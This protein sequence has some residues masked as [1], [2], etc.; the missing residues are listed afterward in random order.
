MGSSRVFNAYSVWAVLAVPLVAAAVGSSVSCPDRCAC[1]AA[2]ATVVCSDWPLQRPLLLHAAPGTRLVLRNSSG[3]VP[4]DFFANVTG[5]Q[6]LELV[7]GA[8]LRLGAR[9]L[10][11]LHAVRR[12]AVVD[13][14]LAE[15]AP[16]VLALL[17]RLESLDLS[18]NRLS[19]LYHHQF[20]YNTHL[21]R[22]RLVDNWLAG[23][24]HADAFEGAERLRELELRGC[25][26]RRAPGA[27]FRHMPALETLD[28]SHNRLSSVRVADTRSWR[29][30]RTLDLSGNGI[31][32]VE[33][34]AFNA[35]ANLTR[36][37][38]SRNYISRLV[39][40]GLEASWLSISNNSFTV[41]NRSYLEL[42]TRLR[43]LQLSDC[44]RLE[45]V[46]RNLLQR[47]PLLER[48]TISRNERL[49][50]IE[51]GTFR[52][53]DL[54]RDVDLG[55]NALQKLPRG[56]AA[57][58]LDRLEVGGNNFS[59]DCSLQWYVRRP[60]PATATAADAVRCR[61]GDSTVPL[62]E[63]LAHIL[64]HPV[65]VT[66]HQRQAWSPHNGT[67][68]LA[69]QPAGQPT[70]ALTWIT[71]QRYVFHW[72]P[73]GSASGDARHPPRHTATLAAHHELDHYTVLP[74]GRLQV[75]PVAA[76]H[77]G[78]YVC[79]AENDASAAAASVF[80]TVGVSSLHDVK[81]M[82]LLMALTGCLTAIAFAIVV[83]L[84]LYIFWKCGCCICCT[85]ELPPRAKRIKGM[86]DSVEQWRALQLAGLRE[87]Y[88]QQV[89]GIKDS[90]YQQ[91]ERIRETYKGQ[92]RYLG[93]MRDYG[94]QQIEGF[95]DQYL[96]QVRP[97]A[98]LL[99]EPDEPG[100]RELHLPAEPHPQV[101]RTSA[102]APARDLQVST[103][104]AEQ[105]PGEPS[106]PL[107]AELSHRHLPAHREHDAAR[108]PVLLRR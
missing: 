55:Q 91:V 50:E 63:G 23:G 44:A 67:A 87:N 61:M 95:R 8:G 77:Q 65:S 49:V 10:A 108:R 13:S 52:H 54:L 59:C 103:E 12:L 36:L 106:R 78:R 11:G 4:D 33:P 107:P 30:L 56:L 80:L 62:S 90:C 26:L 76:R 41:A 96:D 29:A 27:W 75:S 53:L 42:P 98:R 81:M 58:T 15:L 73:A 5:V 94:A 35:T 1:M 2:S 38:L 105:D 74:D 43:E 24:V 9:S 22:L 45:H 99:P 69:C 102:R 88:N 71:P 25:A 86:L 40:S 104:D 60:P 20:T 68:V 70:P 89:A 101:Q 57:L 83:R 48:L 17:P 21:R 28:L 16:H 31:A 82:A 97:G 39:G 100:A 72:S 19:R 34:G 85:D 32:H 64:C 51:H 66:A 6:A 14:D 92:A 3:T 46:G 47:A 18:R 93:D 84:S 37:D 79:L 7:G